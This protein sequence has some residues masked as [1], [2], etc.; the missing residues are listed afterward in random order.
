MK[1]NYWFRTTLILVLL[2]CTVSSATALDIMSDNP[3]LGAI[4]VDAATGR[5]LFE[6]N[7]DARGYPASLVK[8]M[9]M[10]VIL[11]AVDAHQ[12]TLDEPVRVTAAAAKIGGSQ[13]YLK[14]NEVFPVDDLLYALIVRSANDA[15][16]ALAIHYAG[17]KDAFVKLMNERAQDIG[18]KDTV[19]HA[20]RYCET[21]RGAPAKA[22]R[23]EVYL[24]QEAALPHGC[25]STL[26]HGEP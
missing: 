24:H 19:F 15:A 21:V 2:V 4:V 17:S 6:D 10:L 11:D 23:P 18:M 22:R 16:T 20:A 8:L 5:V 3:Y 26:R 13:V 7:A 1:T 14:E 25:R 12:L 9:V